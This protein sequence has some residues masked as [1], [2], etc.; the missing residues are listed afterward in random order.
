ME[1]TV[2]HKL[3][4]TY[5]ETVKSIVYKTEKIEVAAK[6]ADIKKEAEIAKKNGDIAIERRSEKFFEA[7]QGAVR[8][9]YDLTNK[10]QS[11]KALQDDFGISAEKAERIFQKAK[12]QSPLQNDFNRMAEQ[13]KLKAKEKPVKD[14]KTSKGART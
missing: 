14:K 12:N 2:R 11:I 4:I 13:S 3:G 6:I 8:K 1:D 7:S 9:S 10:K 5:P